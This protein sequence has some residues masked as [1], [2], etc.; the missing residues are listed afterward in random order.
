MQTTTS[1]LSVSLRGEAECAHDFNRI[2]TKALDT[3][4]IVKFLFSYSTDPDA[5]PL[6]GVVFKL[7][8]VATE[9]NKAEMHQAIHKFVGLI[10]AQD[11][12]HHIMQTL[13]FDEDKED[14]EDNHS[15]CSCASS[16]TENCDNIL[17]SLDNYT[18]PLVA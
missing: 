6:P 4:P 8:F 16:G 5:F 17:A 15:D 10:K 2:L 11:D 14:N 12:A 9:A 1:F 3:A 13:S 7:K 18:K